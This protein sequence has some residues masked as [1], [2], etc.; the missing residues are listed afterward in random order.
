VVPDPKIAVESIAVHSP[1]AIFIDVDNLKLLQDFEFEAQ[2]RFG[3]FS[4]QVQSSRFHF[5]S[6]KSLK[7]NRDVILSPFFSSYY[8]RPTEN[9]ERCAKLYGRFVLAGENI[10]NYGLKHFLNDKSKTQSI[11]LTRSDQKHEATEAL[12]QYLIQ[13]K[14][15]ARIA[16]TIATSVDEVLMNAIFDAPSDDFGQSLYN[17]T[18]RD[19]VRELRGREQVTLTIGFDGFYIGVSVTDL[20]GS[21][22]RTRLLN[23]V[24]MNYRDQDYE[25]KRG[26]AGAGL[27]LATIFNSGGSVIYH[28]EAQEKTDVTLLY[29]A[30]TNFREFK[31]QF[32]FF[33]AKFYV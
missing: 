2:K 23:H 1:A 9:L 5:I 10:S 25:I 31:N 8:E 21:I 17:A 18:S 33:S 30:C 13:A 3:L 26:R 24:S 14:V 6:N 29:Q 22:D 16:N 12:R 19:E 7:E 27:G 32:R 20:F 4:D 15:P 28:C 11:T